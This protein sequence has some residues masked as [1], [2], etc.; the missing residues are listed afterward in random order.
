MASDMFEW[1]ILKDKDSENTV[2]PAEGMTG[3]SKDTVYLAGGITGLSYEDATRW[4][5][6]VTEILSEFGYNILDPMRDNDF[7]HREVKIDCDI[8]KHR[9]HNLS[10]ESIF[11][12]DIQDIDN[13]SIIFARL[14]TAK[15][16]G[17]PFEIGYA[18]AKGKQI[19]LIVPEAM[20]NHPF[21]SAADAVFT[22]YIKAAQ[23]LAAVAELTKV[24]VQGL[25][26]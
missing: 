3:L 4:R 2:H 14:D 1:E 25:P 8:N 10:S 13:S 6:E 26:A 5:N 11:A 19:I 24:A 12:K 22:D 23:V 16:F 21:C 7:L 20:V 18:Y 9:G 17:T 15:G